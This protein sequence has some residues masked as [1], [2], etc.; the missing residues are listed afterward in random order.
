MAT[1]AQD[2]FDTLIANQD[3]HAHRSHPEDASSSTDTSEPSS[4]TET[5]ARFS[6]QEDETLTNHSDTMPSS[7][8]HIPKGTT[9]DANTGPKGVIAD[10]K[11]FDRA[12]KRGF[13]QTLYAFSNGLTG[14]V[15]EKQKTSPPPNRRGASSS[16]D[17][18]ADDDEDDFM[19][20][21]RTKRMS[22]MQ[23]G[24]QDRR[25]RR[26]SPSKR[27]YGYVSTVD[28]IGYL[29]AVEKVASDTVVVVCIYDDEVCKSKL[30]FQAA[31]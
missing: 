17:S 6:D 5:K 7:V 9:F 26:Q 13:R 18:S 19:R 14:T 10:V 12:R 24:G 4:D 2:E 30:H 27:R 31:A 21:W 23:S 25:T 3:R 29:D 15:F 8:Y 1:A 22:E 20:E 28:A 16:T 11:S